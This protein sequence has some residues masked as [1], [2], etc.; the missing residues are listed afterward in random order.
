MRNVD[1]N[2]SRPKTTATLMLP[3]TSVLMKSCAQFDITT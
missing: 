1:A 3:T 2:C